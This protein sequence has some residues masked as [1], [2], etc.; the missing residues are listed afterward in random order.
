MA[1]IGSDIREILEKYTEERGEVGVVSATKY[2][3]GRGYDVNEKFVE[4]ILNNL[5]KLQRCSL[6]GCKRYRWTGT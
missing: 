1:G 5:E 3:R 2:I 4:Q 6:D